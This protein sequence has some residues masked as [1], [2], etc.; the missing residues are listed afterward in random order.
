[1]YQINKDVNN[2]IDEKE[3]QRLKTQEYKLKDINEVENS[4]PPAYKLP[5]NKI[6]MNTQMMW[7]DIFTNG[8]EN[9]TNNYFFY[10]A[11]TCIFIFLLY[12]FLITIFDV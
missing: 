12:L 1:M 9:F 4:I 5:L 10:I 8:F 2:Y 7:F 3:K 6:L 11:I